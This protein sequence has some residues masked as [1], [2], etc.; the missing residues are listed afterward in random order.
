MIK[1]KYQKFNKHYVRKNKKILVK[2]Y[3]KYTFRIISKKYKKNDTFSLMDAGCALVLIDYLSSKFRKAS[4]AGLDFSNELIKLAK[5]D[6]SF[7]NFY[8]RNLLKNKFANTGKK[9]DVVTCVT[10]FMLLTI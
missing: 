3:F 10:R 1:N 6:Y 8:V 7:A 2:D 4:F 5:K 9:Y